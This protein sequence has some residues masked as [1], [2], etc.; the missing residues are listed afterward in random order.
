MPAYD[1][2]SPRAVR[3]PSGRG[4]QSKAV[5]D[6]KGLDLTTPVDLLNDGRTPF[7]K[8]FRLYAQQSDDRRVAVSSRKGPGFY[9]NPLNEVLENNN[10]STAGASVAKVGIINGVHAQPFVATSN[11][12]LTRID[13]K[14]SD[15]EQASGP[16]LVSI[17]D[18]TA[19]AYR[20]LSQSSILSGDIGSNP[21]YVSARFVDAVK[22]VSGQEY[23][24]VLSMQDDGKNMY[25]ISTTTSGTPALKSDAGLSQLVPQ[26]YSINFRLYT[27]LD[28]IDKGAYRYNRDNGENITIVAYGDSLYK[29]DEST[30]SLVRI[31]TGLNPNAKEYRFA[32]GDNKIFFVNGYDNLMTWNA[33]DE[34]SAANIVNN[35]SFDVDTSGWAARSGTTMSRSTT[36]PNSAPASLSLS[37]VSGIRGAYYIMAMQRMRRYK[38]TFWAK[39]TTATGSV[40][41]ASRVNT[42]SDASPQYVTT[43]VGSSVKPVTTSWAKY[44]MYYT[45]GTDILGLEFQFSSDSGFIDD[46]SVTDSGFE[47]ITH[48]NLPIAADVIMHKDQLF[49]FSANEPNLMRYSYGV[50]N[51]EFDPTGKIATPTRERWY[52][53]WPSVNFYNVPG[54]NVGSPITAVI[55]FQDALTIFTADK[56]YVWSGFDRGSYLLREATGVKGCL[57]RRGAT[58]DE[59][60][61]Y[62]VAKDGLYSYNGSKDTKISNL[63]EPLFDACGHKP[64]ITPVS[65]GGQVRFYMASQGSNVNDTCLIYEKDLQ[66]MEY[67]TDTFVN[68]ALFYQDADDEQQLIEFSSVAPTAYIAEQ[69]YNSLGA[70]ID[71]EYRLNYDSMNAPAQR[72]RLRRYYPLLQGVDST[73]PIQLA[74]DKDFQDSPRVKDQMLVTNGAK[75]GEF[76]WGDGTVFGGNTSFKPKR[77]SYSGYAHYWQLR[78]MRKAVNNRVAFIGAQFSYKTKRL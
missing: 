1:Y 34:S 12:R 75:W 9:I 28:M 6:L 8:N 61:I 5:L 58:S 55:P 31:L 7:A 42:G 16:L 50:G 13:I 47:V 71:F 33:S 65:W 2:T 23:L 38:V 54:V 27:A 60:N 29:V 35:P 48:D 17:Y 64:E 72:K 63:V 77:Q 56:K 76:K 70:P 18:S 25:D 22:L 11:N 30:N 21:S 39:G 53:N 32:N 74:M 15:S 37:A 45:P 3:A 69:G 10:T 52:Y 19:G 41:F 73:F 57:S 4:D 46:V 67:D 20:L 43:I 51:P 78:V 14:V 40:Q 36:S 62:F 68:R 59:N 49:V 66:E 24:I 44:E 26:T